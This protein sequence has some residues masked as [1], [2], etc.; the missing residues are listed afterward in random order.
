MKEG[1]ERHFSWG[2][3]PN[4]RDSLVLAL[5]CVLEV[6]AKEKNDSINCLPDEKGD[7]R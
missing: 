1:I 4:P 6:P 2:P 3:S 5:A 7:E